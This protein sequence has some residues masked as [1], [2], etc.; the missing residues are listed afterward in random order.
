MLNRQIFLLIVHHLLITKNT[1]IMK[2]KL[3]RMAAVFFA[4]LLF[5]CASYAQQVTKAVDLVKK[6]VSEN[7]VF[8]NSAPG[9]TV[10]PASLAGAIQ[11]QVNG[12]NVFEWNKE[13]MAALNNA[14]TIELVLPLKG[15]ATV[16]LQLV[17]TNI[18]TADYLL[19]TSDGKKTGNPGGKFY[20][21][22]VKGDESSLAAISIYEDEVAGFFTLA[23]SNYVVGKIKNKE[24]I[25]AN[26]VY[27]ES[28]LVA[29]NNFSCHTPDAGVP[30]PGGGGISPNLTAR[31]VRLYYEAEVD[32]YTAFGSNSTSVSNYVT[33]LFNQLKTLYNNDGIS[34]S[35]SQVFVWTTTDPYTA[36][37]VPGTLAQFQATRT[38][39]N[40]DLGQ[41]ITT[42][43]IG[44]GQAAGFTG[45]CNGSI[46]QR[47]C[48]SG[49]LTTS[50]P[51]VPSYS[52]EVYVTSHEF[53]HL[54]GS[55]H[56]H[57]CVWNGNNTAIDGCSGFVE[58]SCGLPG[59]PSGGGTI[60]SYC[61][62]NVG[63][64]F[65]LGFGPQP[66]Q[67]IRNNVEAATCLSSCGGTT[68][69]TTPTGLVGFPDCLYADLVWS[70]VPGAITYRVEYKKTTSTVWLVANAATPYTTSFISGSAGLY[71]WRVQATC[72]S[73][74][75]D[76][77][78][79]TVRLLNTKICLQ[80]VQ[81]QNNKNSKATGTGIKVTPLP[82]RGELTVTY[83]ADN[84]GQG[85]IIIVNQLGAVVF[86]STTAVNKGANT[87]KLNVSN[88][89]AGTYI[90][91]LNTK[92][93]VETARV[94]IE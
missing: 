11:Q 76:W 50:F 13:K 34:V 9:S 92:G 28:D 30:P 56:T 19:V 15:N 82:A 35:L 6:A 20:Q 46:A 62:L 52:W 27:Q 18:F 29:K 81:L 8:I 31:C 5:T 93:K 68:G 51:N 33:N 23:G 59:T 86:N 61:H 2:R 65:S 36:T 54:F 26:I 57:A 21:G 47:L 77:A 69:C 55:R 41:L 91:R 48:V 84:S 74:T 25:G 94:V 24:A 72:A 75:S 80:R 42:R 17:E 89:S 40:G 49:N 60:M 7:K 1:N 73:G 32:F 38:S 16:T 12:Y 10:L 87:A 3:T 79:A 39:F 71:N 22:I 78:N 85:A 83:T 4:A 64:N 67:L 90:L 45:L 37:D 63:I 70:A 88:L 44:G 53:G 66:A 14:G 58:G 43:G